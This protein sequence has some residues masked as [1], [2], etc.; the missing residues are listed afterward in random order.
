[1]VNA[2]AL[3]VDGAA[4]TSA[5]TPALPAPS[6]TATAT[7]QTTTVADGTHTLGARATDRAGTSASVSRVVIVDNTPPDAQITGGPSG[8][9]TVDT[10]TFTFTGTDNLTSVANLQFAWRFDGGAF[11]AFGAATTA[12]FSGLT[13]GPHAFEVKARDLAGN[14]D[15]T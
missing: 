12:S 7:W 5:V 15:P 2:L 8:E 3:T 13:E 6:A 4:L 1:G 11:T 14:E 10:T 9:I